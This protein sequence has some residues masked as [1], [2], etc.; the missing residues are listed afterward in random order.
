MAEVRCRCGFLAPMK[1]SWSYANPGKR[2]RACPR[3]G[4]NDSCRYF[5]WMDYNVSERVTNVLRGLLKR[6]NK[7][8]HEIE[9]LQFTIEK[10]EHEIKKKIWELNLKFLYGF[11]FGVLF[12]VLVMSIWMR[13]GEPSEGLLQLK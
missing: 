5:E 3:Y 13:S 9:K 6:A 12:A 1:M 7:Y 2:Y 8:E 4:G 11:G 10:K